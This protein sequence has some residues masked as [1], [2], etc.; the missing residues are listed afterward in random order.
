VSLGDPR[1]H[2]GREAPREVRVRE[3]YRSG[4]H[5]EVWFSPRHSSSQYN[6]EQGRRDLLPIP[7]HLELFSEEQ[8]LH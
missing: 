7:V 5:P 4:R 1:A 2:V 3:G 8:S 6:G